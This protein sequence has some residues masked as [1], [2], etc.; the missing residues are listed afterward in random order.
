MLTA[1]SVSELGDLLFAVIEWM[2]KKVIDVDGERVR[3]TPPPGTEFEYGT[4]REMPTDIRVLNS[5][6]TYYT[7]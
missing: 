3:F 5:I 4:T 2:E 6:H 7:A 1:K